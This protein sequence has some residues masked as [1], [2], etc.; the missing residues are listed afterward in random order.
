[1]PASKH[2]REDAVLWEQVPT[3]CWD[4]EIGQSFLRGAER[5]RMTMRPHEA[6]M[7]V[8]Q[9]H[10]IKAAGKKLMN[11]WG[12]SESDSA[13]STR[14]PSTAP[15]SPRSVVESI[16]PWQSPGG[17]GASAGETVAEN[18]EPAM[19][20][21]AV[22]AAQE[23]VTAECNLNLKEKADEE[24]EEAMTRLYMN[25]AVQAML[26]MKKA[27]GQECTKEVKLPPELEEEGKMWE[28]FKAQ[29]FEFNAR[30]DADSGTGKMVGAFNRGSTV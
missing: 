1:M 20:F 4:K 2:A 11:N 22:R 21:D 23:A 10:E 13:T 5:R 15:S 6:S 8:H 25:D 19:V 12:R 18:W 9:L 3:D 26:A 17:M 28:M 16:N 27:D 29:N 30:G 14:A 24:L 7:G